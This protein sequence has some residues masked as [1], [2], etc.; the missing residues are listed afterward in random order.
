MTSLRDRLSAILPDYMV[1]NAFVWLDRLPAMP[2]GKVDRKSLPAPKT[3]LT[4]QP[5]ES[6]QPATVLEVELMRIWQRLFEHKNI[7][8]NDNFFDLGGHSLLAIRLTAEIEKF[9][10]RQ[11]PIA[12]LFQA[13]TVASLARK[14]EDEKWVPARTSLV[15]LQPLGA[16]LPVFCIHGIHGDVY[17]FI[18]LSR[19]LAPDRPVYGLQAVGLDGRQPRHQTVEEMAAHYAMEIRSV[20]PHGPYHLMGLSLGGWIAYAVAQELVRTGGKVA[21]LALLDTR[22]TANV[23]WP[24]YARFMGPHLAGRMWFHAR[25]SFKLQRGDRARYLKEKLKSLRLWVTRARGNFQPPAQPNQSSPANSTKSA[26]D[27][28]DAAAARYR[29]GTYPG[30]VTVF[31]GADG[32]FFHHFVFWNLF[33]TGRVEVITVAGDHHTLIDKD[34]IAEFAKTFRQALRQAE[35]DAASK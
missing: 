14:L 13:P 25:K 29:P 17:R 31:A 23:P 18:E 33:V 22:A 8:R 19:E 6:T 32:K 1:P 21:L 2:N 10:G 3:D 34:R 26:I 12:A 5:G 20:H 7:S 4:A 16:E 30:N 15:P 24:V 9:A 11:I 28:F 35:T 27:Y